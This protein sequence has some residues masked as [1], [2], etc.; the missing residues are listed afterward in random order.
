MNQNI[1]FLF[2]FLLITFY[3]CRSSQEL[4]YLKDAVPNEIINGLTAQSTGHILKSGDILYV[5]IKTMNAEVNAL[6]NPESNM[7]NNTGQGYQKF[8]SPSGAY[9]YGFEIDSDGNIKLPM[10]GKLQVADVSVFQVESIV[11]K[12][13]DEFI[14]DAIVKVKLLNF[15]ITVMG[16][17]RSPGVYYN[18]NNSLTVIEALAMANGNTD[19]ASIRKVMVVRPTAAGNRSYMLDLSSIDIFSSEAFYLHSNDMIIVQPD[20]HKNFQLN[21]QAYSLVLSSLSV[22]I[23]VLGFVL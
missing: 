20:K 21:S 4:I 16:E 11:Q 10:L 6:F 22:L 19:F 15:K 9:L 5:S 12:K 14:K 1:K 17:V 23:A 13:A 2:L 7:E 3:S 8:T 18:Y